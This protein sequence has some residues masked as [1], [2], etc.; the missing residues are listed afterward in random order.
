MYNIEKNFERKIPN[1]ILLIIP[2]LS[3]LFTIL[4]KYFN[5]KYTKGI[6]YFFGIDSR[7]IIE[8]STFNVYK[9]SAMLIITSIYLLT[10]INI[11]KIINKY[12][13]INRIIIFSVGNLITSLL[14]YFIVIFSIIN[15]H[16]LIMNYRVIKHLIFSNKK[17]LIIVIILNFAFLTFLKY[18]LFNNFKIYQKRNVTTNKVK[19]NNNIL[20]NPTVYFLLLLLSLLF[21]SY[22]LQKDGY[23]TAESQLS[24]QITE[25][26]DT[27]FLIAMSDGDE[28]ILVNC[29]YE[30]SNEDILFVHK[31]VYMKVNCQN[32]LIKE[33]RFSQGIKLITPE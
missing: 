4:S 16:I 30:N 32:L 2:I 11:L 6:A 5:Y 33:K 15:D 3:T 28:A 20:H 9:F 1:T 22:S 27:I 18:F 14:L 12:K 8:D 10:S 25:I 21:Y 23:N 17:L 7:F 26:D 24:Y 19:D 29:D 13:K 31:G